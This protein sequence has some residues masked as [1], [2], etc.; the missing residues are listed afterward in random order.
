[1]NGETQEH[2]FSPADSG[3]VSAASPPVKA[4]G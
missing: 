4:Q 1:M 2:R 3:I